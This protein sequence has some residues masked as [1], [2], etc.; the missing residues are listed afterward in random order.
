MLYYKKTGGSI[1]EKKSWWNGLFSNMNFWAPFLSLILIGVG[2]WY[3][4]Q[5][6]PYEI[7]LT[8][9]IYYSFIA[10]LFLAMLN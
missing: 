9:F 2:S 6:V 7:G 5:G 3:A 10:S 1:M 4:H 8:K